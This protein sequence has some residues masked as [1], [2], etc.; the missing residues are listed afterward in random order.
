MFV[1]TVMTARGPEGRGVGSI[2]LAHAEHL[3]RTHGAPALALD[4]WADSPELARIYDE[5]GYVT[6]A[7]YT[8]GHEGNA[9]RNLVRVRRLDIGKLHPSAS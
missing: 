5:H 8:D 7:E 2:L 6:V 3:A 4:H 1:H 9:V